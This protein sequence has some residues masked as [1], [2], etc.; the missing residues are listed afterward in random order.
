MTQ[1]EK[2]KALEGIFEAE[3]GAI[4]P[5]TSLDNLSWDSMSRLSLIALV[6]EK[7]G[8]QLNGSQLRGFK[9]VQDILAVMEP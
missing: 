3:A 5:E 2:I 9:T 4:K 8:K 1:Q 6:T 7:F